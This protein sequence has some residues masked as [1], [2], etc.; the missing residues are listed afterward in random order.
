[1]ERRRRLAYDGRPLSETDLNLRQGVSGMLQ[2]YGR[3]YDTGEAVC[4]ETEGDRIR[5]VESLPSSTDPGT[6]P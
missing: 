1:M 5:S 3:R 4:I 6:L 2:I